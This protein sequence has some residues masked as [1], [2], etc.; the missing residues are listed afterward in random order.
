M[1]K[2]AA[3]GTAGLVVLGAAAGGGYVYNNLTYFSRHIG[4]VERAGVT[5]KSVDI[6]GR[7]INYAE[8]PAGGAV[9]LLIHGQSG[10]WQNYARV[11]PALTEDFHV[12]AVD[13]FGHGGSAWLPETYSATAHGAVLADFIDSVIG[14]PV[15]VSGHS[16]GGHLAAWLAANA[17]QHV[18]AVVME[19][20]PLFTTPL[21][22]AERTWNYVDLATNAHRFLA[23]DEDDFV[24]YQ[25]RHT[26]MWQFFGDDKDWFIDQGLSHRAEYPDEPI[27]WWSLPP[28]LNESFRALDGYDPRFGDTFFT[29]VWDEDFDHAATLAGIMVPAVLIHTNV[30]HDEDGVLM[31]AMDDDDAA[32]ARSL[33][34]NLQFHKVNSGHNFHWEKPK[35]FV[36][37]LLQLK[38]RLDA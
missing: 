18:R 28:A 38:S 27:T 15:I 14:E 1:L 32:R 37:I 19:D 7:R 13:C 31:A 35:D 36:D 21:P 10:D 34:P 5:E 16:S 24:A 33:I 20:P 29:G 9:L 12:F 4:A 2:G 22:R 3:W 25:A 26:R 11:L 6:D 17:S 23:S 30:D 8:G